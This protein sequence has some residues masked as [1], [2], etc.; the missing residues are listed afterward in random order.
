MYLFERN[1][2]DNNRIDVYTMTPNAERIASFKKAEMEQIPAQ[3]RVYKTTCDLDFTYF[4]NAKIGDYYQDDYLN[5]SDSGI[6][7]GRFF[8]SISTYPINDDEIVKQNKLLDDYYKS[9]FKDKPIVC[10]FKIELARYKVLKYLLLTQSYNKFGYQDYY[11]MDNIILVPRTLY[12]LQL[13]E[14]E[15]IELLSKEIDDYND[16]IS[17]QLATFDIEKVNG[18]SFSMDIIGQLY[19]YKLVSGARCYTNMLIDNSS[20]ILAKSRQQPKL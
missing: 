6:Y 7:G 15:K 5:Y 3:E 9:E 2:N 1:D 8:H 11:T 14:Q 12:L 4:R 16:D 19:D 10:T 13:L 20:K 18:T 17:K